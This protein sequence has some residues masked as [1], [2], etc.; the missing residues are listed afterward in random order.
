MVLL[1]AVPVVAATVAIAV[2]LSSLRTV[3][4]LSSDLAT[5][6]RRSRDLRRPLSDLRDELDRSQP[7]VQRVFRH[8]EQRGS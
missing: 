3:E 8:W 2:V 1:W 5:A 6:V 4:D 7:V